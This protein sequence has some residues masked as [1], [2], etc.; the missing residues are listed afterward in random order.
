VG[1]AR[2]GE[3]KR[4]RQLA[5]WGG[6]P[7]QENG[8]KKAA[9]VRKVLYI[10][11]LLADAD[12]DWMARV[13]VRRRMKDGEILIEQGKA[14]DSIILL[15]EGQLSVVVKDVG[16]VA[17]LGVGEIVGEMSMVDSAPPSATVA[18]E[19]GCLILSLDKSA[20]LQKLASDAPFG[21]RFYK[22]LAVFLADRLRAMEQRSSGNGRQ[23]LAA[24]AISKD[25]LDDGILDHVAM[26]GDRF[27]RM[28]KVL[29]GV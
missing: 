20:L 24:E 13:G 10:F 23:D 15:L 12:I 21:S 29:T 14:I 7:P 5:P 2:R 22:A 25:E 26:A 11:G 18:A 8:I 19:G 28:L 9:R 27:D 16:I 6:P 1:P 3:G 17:R 4:G